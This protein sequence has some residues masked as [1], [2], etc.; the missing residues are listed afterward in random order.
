[1]GQG[2]PLAFE[3][4][5]PADGLPLLFGRR[6]ALV[7]PLEHPTVISPLALHEVAL[8]RTD[9]LQLMRAQDDPTDHDGALSSVIHFSTSRGVAL[10]GIGLEDH[11][12]PLGGHEAIS[13]CTTSAPGT[14]TFAIAARGPT[15]AMYDRSGR[16]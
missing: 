6:R 7:D 15:A 14:V 9:A 16:R 10:H 8:P 12:R 1:R 3:I 4:A 13:I 11:E 5:P 2:V